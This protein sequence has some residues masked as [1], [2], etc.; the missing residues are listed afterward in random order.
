MSTP[1][2]VK[3]RI[4]GEDT[5][6]AAAIKELSSQLKNL[7]RQ[8][9]ETA[10]SSI[11]LGRAFAGL[12]TI[13][14]T[15]GLMRIGKEAFDSAV[16][17]GKMSDKTGLTT[18]TLSVF[19]KVA[20]DVGVATESV[21]RGLTR[22]TRS[23]TDFEAG[24]KKAALAFQLLGITQKDFA[25]LKPDEKIS[26]VTDRV[27]KMTAGFQKATATQ[28]IFSKGG[29]EMIPVLNALAAQGFDNVTEST[30][31]LGLLL[32]QQTTDTF[33][34]AKAAIQEIEDAGRGMATQFEAGLLPAISDVADGLMES[35]GDDGAGG[36]FRDLGKTVGTVIRGIAFGLES[37]GIAAGHAAAE[38]EEVFDYAFNHTKEFAKTTWAA[39]G[40]YIRGGSAGAAIAAAAQVT[41]AGDN[42]TKEFAA[43]IAAID[44]DADEQQLKIYNALFPSDEEAEKRRKARLARL[45]SE[46]TTEGP[47]ASTLIAPM[48]ASAKAAFA[49]LEKQL[50]DELAI[51]R[52]YAKESE[53]VEKEQYEKGEIS[54]ASYFE[55]RRAAV[56][57]DV[58]AEIEILKR[59]LEA[60]RTDAQRLAKEK[61]AAATPAA[62]DKL[63]AQRL[64]TLAKVD[65]FQTKI[66]QTQ[67][68]ASTK[69]H[70]LDTEEF[71]A[72]EENQ[73]KLLEFQK[74][75]EK[76]KGDGLAE[77][78][79][80]I[81]IEKQ[82]MAVILA[83]A[84]LSKQEI[85]SRLAT[86]T[87]VKTAE[88]TLTEEE[89]DGQAALKQ[90]AD[91]RAAIEDQ[92]KNGKLFQVQAD[93]RIRQ[94]ELERLPV[95]QQMA[96]VMLTQAKATGDQSKIAAAEDFQKQ[97]N[98]IATQTNTVGQQVA[99]L[100]SGIQSSLTGGLEEFFGSL[101]RGTQSVGQAFRGMAA[102]II[103]SLARMT[104]QMMAQ[105][106]ITKLLKATLGGFAGGGLVP[107]GRGAAGFAE[108]GLIRGPGGPK[109]DSIP[110]RVSPGEYI[111]KADA[112]AQFG[113]ANL[114]AINRGLKV[115]SIERLALPRYAEGGLVG[116]AEGGGSSR[117][118][119]GIGLDEGLILKHLSSNM[120]RD[121]ILNHIANNPKAAAKALSRSQ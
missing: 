35:L 75:I 52:A 47:E 94:V 20:G 15:I 68:A 56:T 114:E 107:G 110:A 92:V 95:L 112:V 61:A 42:A 32:D 71:K 14:G 21:D 91:Q 4:L 31:K 63:E 100:R 37:V 51:R 8:Q 108:G 46:K 10:G 67:T 54:L 7:K 90:L 9:D 119:L 65:E 78:L 105:I 121:V 25:G 85:A 87:Q 86:Y 57:E 5:G 16:N 70:A 84:G 6:V 40:G 113:V 118:N 53:Q 39:I 58:G 26:L 17:I 43:R 49:L 23:I 30:R 79:K 98:Q 19:H 109:S 34:E 99:M 93:E 83:Q 28:L 11:S 1:P 102:S 44:K 24:G 101:V 62:A 38:V 77:A 36:S 27:G 22:A 33:R 59:G 111:V 80:E 41:E 97:V 120:A 106:L 81:E 2:D 96:A 117:I 69:V 64:E 76:T 73:T 72:R 104:A 3:V 45:R 18:Q 115:P 50:Q 55:H 12:A 74:L 13:A 116:H 29:A 66:I 103:T 60:A 89:Q 48:E 82:K 88:A